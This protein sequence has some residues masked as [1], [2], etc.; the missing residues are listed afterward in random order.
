[1]SRVSDLSLLRSSADK[2]STP[3][4]NSAFARIL[5]DSPAS[6]AFFGNEATDVDDTTMAILFRLL[7]LPVD[8]SEKEKAA[9]S[10]IL[11]GLEETLG[12]TKFSHF[13]TLKADII[14]ASL[15]DVSARL[16]ESIIYIAEYS[17]MSSFDDSTEMD[18]IIQLVDE[19]RAKASAPVP[20]QSTP[21]VST[22]LKPI[23]L[24]AFAGTAHKF[25]DWD[26]EVQN[27]AGQGRV[28]NAITD[29]DFGRDPNEKEISQSVFFSLR[30]ALSKGQAS[31][32]AEEL[33]AS[34]NLNAYVL[35][36]KLLQTY[37]D[38]FSQTVRRM[39]ILLKL[40]S[41][42]LDNGDDPG[43]FVNQFRLLQVRLRKLSLDLADHDVLLRTILFNNVRSDEMDKVR[44]KLQTD[45][46][47]DLTKTLDYIITVNS[48]LTLRDGA[49]STRAARRAQQVD[50]T[51]KKPNL[52]FSTGGPPQGTHNI[53]TFPYDLDKIVPKAGMKIL[54]DWRKDANSSNT[55]GAEL[56]KKYAI[57]TKKVKR[58]SQF[59]DKS[60]KKAR[61][62]KQKETEKSTD[63][64]E[65]PKASG[66]GSGV[67]YQVFAAHTRTPVG[68]VKQVYQK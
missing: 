67:E 7:D 54:W 19:A 28:L 46:S 61:R 45:S 5:Q 56:A 38:T 40:L 32:L 16:I 18:S 55:S 62:A 27:I 2:F 6:A 34:Q 42:S 21:T 9:R 59:N 30:K 63:S 57:E 36:Q 47:F 58:S 22:T 24:P 64:E 60:S 14:S 39:S 12:C 33:H 35:Y 20:P 3:K 68:Q 31:S 44:D 26:M 8:G 17:K 50:A 51:K 66:Y 11:K 29:K 65:Q 49:S 48:N 53:P 15:T 13:K 10:K 1:M 41:L 23:D 4:K 52:P 25:D 43:D 37:S